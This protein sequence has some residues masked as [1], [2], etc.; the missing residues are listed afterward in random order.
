MNTTEFRAKIK[1]G[2]IDVPLQYQNKF[3]SDVRVI[4]LNRDYENTIATQKNSGPAKGFGALAHRA[5][6]SLWEQEE[7]A[8]E[9]AVVNNYADD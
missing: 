7:G 1:N 4:I 8:W 3:D 5:A 2:K 9:R 6:P